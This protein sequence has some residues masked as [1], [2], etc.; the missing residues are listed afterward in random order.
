MSLAG[1]H[2]LQASQFDRSDLDQIFAV[3]DQL[4]PVALRT[5]TVD[6]L[7]G[8]VLANLFFEPSTRTR[9]S[10]GA[11]FARLGGTVLD[12]T[13]LQST[14]MAKGESLYDTARVVAGY[15]DV[16]VLRSPEAGAVE[17]FARGTQIPVINA[18]DGPREHPTQAL[19]D[20]YTIRD[21]RRRNG[22]DLDGLRITI[23]GDLKYGRTVH[24]LMHLLRL[25]RD[26]QVTLIAEDSLRMPDEVVQQA[27]A[28]GVRVVES[29]TFEEGLRD[30]DVVYMTRI[31]EE[32]FKTPADFSRARGKYR[33]TRPLFERLCSP[34]AVIMHPLPRDSRVESRELDDDL[35]THPRLAIF[36]QT[37]NGVPVRMALFALVLGCEAHLPESRRPARWYRPAAFGP[38]DAPMLPTEPMRFER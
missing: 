5:E 14:S 8:A 4:R 30:A 37:D 16:I 3:A 1:R 36:R 7:R 31:Q 12:T 27:R 35:T 17:E 23:V 19:L 28:G 21:E 6:V 20:V 11:A 24:S 25:Y 34:S 9:V 33:L 32:R 22:R 38:H 15:V 13:G 10:F 26:V 29:A 2:I 18:G